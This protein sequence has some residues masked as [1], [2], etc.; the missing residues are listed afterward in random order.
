MDV[1]KDTIVAAVTATGEVG[2][3]TAYGTFPNTAAAL[4]TLVKRLRQAGSGPI[5]FCYEAGP[6]GHGVH[7]TLTKMG[8]D[9]MVVAPS[10][11]P[12]KS[13]DRAEDRQARYRQLGRVAPRRIVDRGLG[14]GC[15]HEAMRDLIRTRLAAVRAV[16]AGRQRLIAFL[17]RHERTY[18]GNKPWTKA[19]RRWLADQK[20]QRRSRP[21]PADRGCAQHAKSKEIVVPSNITLVTLLP[22]YSPE[23]NPAGNVWE[24]PR[25]NRFGAQVWKSYR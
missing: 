23:L 16:R 4:E 22:P 5:K 14:A 8:E 9:C 24:F 7:R 10:M 18:P 20:N 3:A 17:L 25:A 19:H 11:I 6:C 21:H 15:A 2:M 13:G 1:H 12:R